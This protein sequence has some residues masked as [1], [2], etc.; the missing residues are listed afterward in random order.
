MFVDAINV[1]RLHKTT[2]VFDVEMYII[3]MVGTTTASK[4]VVASSTV[5][6]AVKGPATHCYIDQQSNHPQISLA[7]TA[8][9]HVAINEN[10]VQAANVSRAL[11]E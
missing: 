2:D 6:I 10:D 8:E 9:K 4:T 7:M 5:D 11:V 1:V 3:L